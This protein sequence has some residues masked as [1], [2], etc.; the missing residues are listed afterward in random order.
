MQ[1]LVVSLTSCHQETAA[2]IAKEKGIKKVEIAHTKI[3]TN[4]N[5]KTHCLISVGASHISH[6]I[7]AKHRWFPRSCQEVSACLQCLSSRATG[8]RGGG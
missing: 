6:K 1:Y 4:L 8:C 7:R 3:Q 2:V 5:L